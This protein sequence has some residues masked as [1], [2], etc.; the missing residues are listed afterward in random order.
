M[1]KILAIGFLMFVV[2]FAGASSVSAKEVG[3]GGGGRSSG[4][5]RANNSWY[6]TQPTTT[7]RGQVLG[8]ETGPNTCNLYL[9]SYLNYGN[10]NNNKAEVAKLQAFLVKFLGVNLPITGV[11]G[12]RTTQA[13]HALQSKYKEEIMA[14]WLKTAYATDTNSTGYVFKTTQWFIN[15]QVCASSTLDLPPLSLDR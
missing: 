15:S 8:A 3:Y 12:P 4:G 2:A 6:L 1:K 14:P 10:D 7:P 9:T 5:S 13:V 11:F